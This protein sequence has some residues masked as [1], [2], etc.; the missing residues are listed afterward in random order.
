MGARPNLVY[1][2]KN[3]TPGPEG[4]RMT[5]EKLSELDAKGDMFWTESGIPR[6]KVRLDGNPVTQIDNLWTDIEAIGSQA[7]ERLGYPTK[8]PEA[9]LERIIKASSNEGDTVLDP[10]CGCGTAIAVA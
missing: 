6:R 10:F 8:K 3:F 7:A 9:L 2:Y 5:R 1:E 4:W